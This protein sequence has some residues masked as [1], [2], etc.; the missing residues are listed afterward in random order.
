MH[1]RPYND[2]FIVAAQII[3]IV[4]FLISWIWWITFLIGFISMILLQVIWCCRQG[5]A[6]MMASAVLSGSTGLLCIIAGIIM[7]ISWQNADRCDTFTLQ[8]SE[9]DFYNSFEFSGN[10]KDDCNEVGWSIVAFVTGFLWLVAAGC[11]FYFV[12]SGRHAKCEANYPASSI[13]SYSNNPDQTTATA[14]AI[15]MATVSSTAGATASTSAACAVPAAGESIYAPM[16]V[17]TAVV[18]QDSTPD[19]VNR[20]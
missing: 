3:S 11:I 18:L 1:Y 7:L 10:Y 2:G 13:N 8:S 4:A 16:A 9:D 6:G 20:V 5:R 17:A 19:K 14:L 15:E 12:K